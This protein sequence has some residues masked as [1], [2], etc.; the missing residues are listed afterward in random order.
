M[1]TSGCRSWLK[2]VA[3][4]SSLFSRQ[5]R[6]CRSRPP[7]QSDFC[8]DKHVS[9]SL[10]TP[11]SAVQYFPNSKSFQSKYSSS[12]ILGDAVL[13]YT[14]Q[15]YDYHRNTSVFATKGN[16]FKELPATKSHILLDRQSNFRAIPSLAML[17]LFTW[18][19]V[20]ASVHFC[21]SPRL[22]T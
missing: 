5:K 3:C 2:N 7:R 13:V 17:S 19:T 6:R 18:L 8:D 14:A 12:T 21:D 10:S 11:C 20:C 16:V 4:L 1:F 22:C 9:C 15:G